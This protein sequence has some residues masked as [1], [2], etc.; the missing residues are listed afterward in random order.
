MK[1]RP[2]HKYIK[3]FT[4]SLVCLWLNLWLNLK[5]FSSLFWKYLCIAEDCI[6]IKILNYKATKYVFIR[7]LKQTS[8]KQFLV[9]LIKHICKYQKSKYPVLVGDEPKLFSL[10]WRYFCKPVDLVSFVTC[11]KITISKIPFWNNEAIL[12]PQHVIFGKYRSS[13]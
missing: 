2:L 3:S 9:I 8:L 6:K 11:S 5:M 7:I 12:F 1:I 4:E 13:E 10:F